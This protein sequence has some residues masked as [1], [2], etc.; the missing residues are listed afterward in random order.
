[1]KQ[2]LQSIK[3]GKKT[4]SK[5]SPTYFIAEIGSNFDR[6]LCR[7]KDLIFLAKESGADAVKIQHYTAATLVSD[8]G[9][10]KLG[11]TQSHQ[12]RW[13]KSVFD[14]YQDASLN[15]SWTQ[16]LKKT[17]DQAGIAFFTSPYSLALVDY[18]D[19][20][21]PAFKI[22][23]GDITW[24]EIIEKI[25]SKNKPV[26]L[27]TGASTMKDVD[28]AVRLILRKNRRLVL[29]QCNTNYEAERNNFP[30]LQLN[31]LKTYA[32]TYPGLLLGLSDHTKGCV[33]VLGAVALGA[34]VIEKHFTDSN[35]RK[36]PD[37]PFAMDPKSWREMVSQ[38]RDLEASM[39]D[40]KKRIEKNELA[41]SIVQR[42]CV[43]VSHN[44]KKGDR[45]TP[46]DLDVLRPCPPMAISPFDMQKVIGKRLKR[47]FRAGENIKWADL[48]N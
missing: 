14:T 5:E 47:S 20:F 40:G 31:V 15:P 24:P 1:M 17:C 19:P 12:A 2:P 7:A 23:S 32:R 46:R 43:R 48:T 22:G 9:F 25:A 26:L 8:V 4:M 41:T 30:F 29:M 36:G 21:V 16:A 45:L 27:A 44:L 42:R 28:R 35:K 11:K 38:T 3:I 18:V 34:R 10:R 13:K 37:H 39:G 6:D 33:S